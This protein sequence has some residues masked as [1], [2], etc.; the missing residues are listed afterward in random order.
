MK[1]CD[2]EFFNPKSDWQVIER[3]L[4]HWMQARAI[5][6]V[7]WR[8][9]DALPAEVLDRLDQEIAVE[10]LKHGLDS[11]TEWKLELA[12]RSPAERGRI[13]W[14]LFAIR[15]RFLDES[16][17]ACLLARPE[18]SKIVEDG[19]R[20]FDEDRYFMTDIVVMPNHVHFIA[21]F[22]DE[23]KFLKQCTD[24]KRFM[25]RE[26]Y[27]K[28]GRTGDYWQTDQYDHLTRSSD[29]F[30]YYRRYVA[31]NPVKGKVPV[32]QFRH[33]QKVLQGA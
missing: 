22:P 31:D 28:V 29:R 4:P 17:G 2:I 1:Q 14:N 12:K 10:L 6:F 16:H 3:K 32:G 20:K 18:C 23:D 27:R 24:W 5:S 9:N 13:N 15:D 30:D 25:A 11:Q 7:T 21:A 19:L 8:A 26:I 33:Y